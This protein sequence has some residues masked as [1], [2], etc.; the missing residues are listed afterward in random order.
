[1]V[2]VFKQPRA[3]YKSLQ[4]DIAYI[5]ILNILI[6]SYSC[7]DSRDCILHVRF[8]SWVNI[9]VGTVLYIILGDLGRG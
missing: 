9:N 4:I 8:G 2:L 6:I 5:Y 1:M 7:Y 3:Q